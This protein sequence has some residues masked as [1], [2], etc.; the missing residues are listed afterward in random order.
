MEVIDRVMQG[1]YLYLINIMFLFCNLSPWFVR[2]WILRIFGMK[3]GKGTYIDRN[4]F[5]KF[6][7][8]VSIGRYTV[9]NRGVEIYSG[10]KSN[11]KVMIGS[12]CRIAPN[13]EIHAAGHD[14]YSVDFEHTGDDVLIGDRVWIGASALILQG[15]RL[16]S[17]SV[18]GAGSIVTKDVSGDTIV[19]GN[20][21]RMLAEIPRAQ[22]TEN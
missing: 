10:I 8:R 7:W 21:A 5:I 20:P 13:V 18:V 4:V 19:A 17:Q 14:A 2:P 11:S 16:H 1:T 9:L 22:E 3:I 15:V 6:P 12:Y